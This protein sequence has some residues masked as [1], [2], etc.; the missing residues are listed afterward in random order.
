MPSEL[1]GASAYGIVWG[2]ERTVAER[3]A[4]RREKWNLVTS[5]LDSLLRY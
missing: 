3:N 5:N 2:N 4:E 1:I